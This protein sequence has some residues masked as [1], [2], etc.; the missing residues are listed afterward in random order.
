MASS[1]LLGKCAGVVGNK[2]VAGKKS[3]NSSKSINIFKEYYKAHK[4]KVC[5]ILE[6]VDDNQ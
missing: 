4:S 2:L 1:K 3:C 5:P 6:V